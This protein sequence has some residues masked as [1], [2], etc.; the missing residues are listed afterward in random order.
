MSEVFRVAMPGVY[1]DLRRTG[2]KIE[3]TCL[4]SSIG[5]GL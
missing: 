4:S 1:R 3:S 5:G 2:A